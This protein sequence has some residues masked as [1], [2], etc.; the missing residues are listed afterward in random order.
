MPN[1]L[2]G[3]LNLTRQNL[4][5][6]I[7]LLETTALVCNALA[8][9]QGSQREHL[10]LHAAL[11]QRTALGIGGVFFAQCVTPLTKQFKNKNKINCSKYQQNNT[12]F[13]VRA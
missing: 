4:P 5:D 6:Y 3:S 10:L 2:R 7:P 11:Q 12:S 1:L 9:A 8:Q 13:E